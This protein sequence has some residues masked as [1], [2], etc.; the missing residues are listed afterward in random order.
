MAPLSLLGAY[1]GIFAVGPY[2][3]TVAP[4]NSLGF[5]A[6]T[7]NRQTILDLTSN[8]VAPKEDGLPQALSRTRL[9]N[10]ALCRGNLETE[11]PHVRGF[12]A[13]PIRRRLLTN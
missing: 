7:A 13:G 10:A 4:S 8:E 11:P 1:C 2:G 3:Q 6:E 12:L 9:R 5:V